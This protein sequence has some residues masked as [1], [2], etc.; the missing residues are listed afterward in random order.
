MAADQSIYEILGVMDPFRFSLF[1]VLLV[2][3][4]VFGILY[5]LAVAFSCSSHLAPFI[6]TYD[7]IS[8][9]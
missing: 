6:S 1:R 2:I 4:L 3:Y 7:P 5:C 8:Y 9:S